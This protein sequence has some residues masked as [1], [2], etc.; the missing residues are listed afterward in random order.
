[1]ISGKFW[2]YNDSGE[3]VYYSNYYDGIKT[4]DTYENNTGQSLKAHFLFEDGNAI[5]LGYYDKGGKQLNSPTPVFQE[6]KIMNDSVYQ[7]KII[8]PFPFKGNMEIYL[9]DSLNFTKDYTNKY[10]LNLKI[11]IHK[12]SW[13]GFDMLLEY[14]PV[15]GDSLM[16]T[17]QVYNH[18]IKIKE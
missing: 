16:W 12:K 17:E 4:G 15:V 5:Y 13:V 11:T 9:Q 8:F 6:E 10:N 3:G 18:T 2:K 7:A 1:M 14:E